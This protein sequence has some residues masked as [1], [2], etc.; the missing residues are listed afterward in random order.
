ML[1]ETS[2]GYVRPV[3]TDQP[4]NIGT[5][6]LLLDN[7]YR[8]LQVGDSN[9][10]VKLTRLEYGVDLRAQWPGFSAWLEHY[11][12]NPADRNNFSHC[13]PGMLASLTPLG[14]DHLLLHIW[15]QLDVLKSSL[16]LVQFNALIFASDH[17]LVYLNKAA[18]RFYSRMQLSD[19]SQLLPDDFDSSFDDWLNQDKPSK[20]ETKFGDQ[21]YRWE[22]SP[23]PNHQYLVMVCHPVADR[24]NYRRILEYA[25][26]GIYQTSRKGE[27]VYA[28][29]S[30]AT[31]FG[32]TSPG[33]MKHYIKQ[34]DLDI[35]QD[36]EDR[37]R[38]VDQV[39]QYDEVIG[40]ECEMF[41][42][43]GESIWVRQNAR[44]V[45]DEQGQLE[46]IIGIV[47]D[48]TDL[49]LAE[50]A[51]IRAEEDLRRLFDNAQSGL[52]QSTGRDQ[53]RFLKVNEMFARM[54]G[55]AD[56]EQCIDHYDDLAREL[57][58][59][60]QERESLLLELEHN[61]QVNNRRVEI[62]RRDG[63]H[64]WVLLNAH[65][66]LSRDGETE[67]LEGSMFDITDQVRAE[68]EIR[69]LAEHDPLTQL[70]NRSRFQHTLEEL[71]THWRS[72]GYHDFLVVF[73]DLDHFKDINDTLGHLV[74]DALLREIASRLQ[75][76]LNSNYETFRLG[77]DEFAMVVDGDLTDTEL[78]ILCRQICERVQR[79]FVLQDNHLKVTA[80]LGVVRG[81]QLALAD[82]ESPLEDIMRAADLALYSC[83]RSGRAS[84]RV[85]REAMREQL[86]S[87]KE[88]ER[89]L[90]LALEKDQLQLYFQPLFNCRTGLVHGAEALIRWPTDDPAEPEGM[91][92]PTRFIPLAERCGLI[93]DI[94]AWVLGQIVMHCEELAQHHPQL[95][96]SFNLSAHHFNFD[97]FNDLVAPIKGKIKR[98]GSN[99]ALELTERVMF[100]NTQRVIQSLNELRQFGVTISLDDFGTGYSSL[101]YLTQ[102]PVDK[103]KID[104]SFIHDMLDN[105]TA[106][107]VVQAAA[108]IGK[109][110][111]LAINAEGI[112]TKAQ[113]DFVRNLD[114]DEVQ[115]FYLAEPMPME[116]LLRF[117]EEQPS[118]QG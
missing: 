23:D 31:L 69:H 109:T 101:S 77:G 99:M 14:D 94:D 104:Q 27:L 82:S 75:Q 25:V 91:I 65:S 54:L 74:G 44:A 18:E 38:F 117:L 7:D 32:F 37:R 45:K 28:N 33:E 64:I 60:N 61:K 41:R 86:Q 81:S 59:N 111:K 110:L 105:T 97:T 84:Y 3:S 22:I 57:W 58:V 47:S 92:S 53:G 30:L 40:F 20:R 42:K 103:I 21:L 98:W 90:A 87:E 96:L 48:I 12:L 29:H 107:A 51:R 118:A 70:P 13:V 68:K 43:S 56:P 78:D 73:M 83:K 106:M 1:T 55:F 89:R 50:R 72:H 26:D 115:G 6:K 71:Y 66:V 95:K 93:A 17:S 2:V 15:R 4:V 46:H 35:Y 36:P 62:K 114:I 19:W 102:F 76:P 52:Y 16:S 5:A 11:S 116:D 100:E 85:Y 112:E 63:S 113:Y 24:E 9:H 108:Q 79:E 39:K 8:L 10:P 88:L 67:I 34:V 49:K 80:S